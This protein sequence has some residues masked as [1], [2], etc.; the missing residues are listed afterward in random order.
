MQIFNAYKLVGWKHHLLSSRSLVNFYSGKHCNDIFL[1]FASVFLSNIPP[2]SLG[3]PPW[4][5]P[6]FFFRQ[7]VILPQKTAT[8]H[9]KEEKKAYSIFW[10]GRRC[11]SSEFIWLTESEV[12]YG[13]GR[14]TVDLISTCDSWI[15]I[16][17]GSMNIIREHVDS[18]SQ[19]KEKC[20][21]FPPWRCTQTL[22]HRS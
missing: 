3:C 5:Q 13:D 2:S 9:E 19:I 20:N 7:N 16:V 8:W 6:S 4:S 15:K 1:T 18:H 21:C 14:I 10:Q 22:K 12:A 11:I 17:R